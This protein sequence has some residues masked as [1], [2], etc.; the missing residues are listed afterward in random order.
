[1]QNVFHFDETKKI[2]LL[3]RHLA[4]ILDSIETKVDLPL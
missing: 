4:T 3:L 2:Y 1:M